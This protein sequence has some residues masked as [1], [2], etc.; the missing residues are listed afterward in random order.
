MRVMWFTNMPMPAMDRRLGIETRGSGWWMTALLELLKGR[1]DIELGVVTA[2]TGCEDLEFRED[3]VEYFV[4]SQ[5]GIPRIARIARVDRLFEN[6]RTERCLKKCAAIVNRWKPDLV[7]C[8]GTERCFGLLGARKMVKATVLVT[9]QGLLRTIIPK[10]FGSL[11]L[12]DIIRAI[13]ITELV[14]GATL[15]RGLKNYKGRVRQE[16]EILKGTE[17]F[18]GQTEWDR[19]HVWSVNASANYHRVGR[20]L[21]RSFYDA[22]WNVRSCRRDSIIFTNA[23]NPL[24]DVESLIRGTEMLR[25]EFPDVKLRLAGRISTRSGYGRSVHRRLARIAGS[26]DLLGYL[27]GERMAEELSASH[28]FAIGSHVENESV[29]LC[30]AM[31]VG[32]PCVASFAGGMPSMMVHGQNGLFFPPGDAAVLAS[33]IRR[34]FLDDVL[35]TRLGSEARRAAAARHDP[36]RVVSDLIAVYEDVLANYGRRGSQ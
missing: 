23:G 19:S 10:Y 6:R 15:L 16:E 12:G 22:R 3:G 13:K 5:E 1:G 11:S 28:V 14:R 8:H 30:E 29:S 24:R 9:I 21:R 4:V 35:A 2:C 26:V 31:L 36:G 34:I 33:R 7:H 18:T 27:N 32:L 17:F 20:A 25:R